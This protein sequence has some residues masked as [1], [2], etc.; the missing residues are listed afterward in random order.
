MKS[1]KTNLKKNHKKKQK[2]K[3]KSKILFIT[4]VIRNAMTVE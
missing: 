4:I 1:I 3:K 2:K